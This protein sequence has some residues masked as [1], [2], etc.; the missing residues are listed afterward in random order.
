MSSQH[1]SHG[2]AHLGFPLGVEGSVRNLNTEE[3]TIAE[4]RTRR[5]FTG[6]F[7]AQAVKRL[8]E[9]D[10]GL[11]EVATELGLGDASGGFSL[12]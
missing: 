1:T 9:G 11:S 5:S 12:E 6:E 2:H 3:G 10:C 4:K 7:K 8:Q